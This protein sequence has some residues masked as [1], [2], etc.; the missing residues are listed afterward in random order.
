MLKPNELRIGN[1]VHHK[2]NWSHRNDQNA[3]KEFDFQ[4]DERDFHG[5]CECTLLFES[6]LEPILINEDWLLKIGFIKTDLGYEIN[7]FVLKFICWNETQYFYGS[8]T[9]IIV[10]IHYI[11]QLQNLYFA[12]TGKELTLKQTEK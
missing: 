7:T 11:H 10:E 3:L 8:I 4:I 6:D 12:I 1:W 5:Y 2:L 9:D